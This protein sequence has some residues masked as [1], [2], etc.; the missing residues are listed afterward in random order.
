[1]EALTSFFA[2]S[3]GEEDIR[4]VYDGTA[5]GLSEA[6]WAPWFSL[7]TVESHLSMVELGTFMADVDLGEMFLNFFLDDRIRRHAGVN[8]T[9]YLPNLVNPGQAV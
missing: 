9:K 2:V 3:K 5:S 6:L 8:L 1:V 4:M 7:P